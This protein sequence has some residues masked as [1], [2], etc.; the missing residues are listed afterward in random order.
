MD[1]QRKKPVV[2]DVAI[3]S[4]SNIKTKENEKLEKQQRL[5]H[6]LKKM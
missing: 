3:P 5:R 6:E 1:K 4:D 2:I